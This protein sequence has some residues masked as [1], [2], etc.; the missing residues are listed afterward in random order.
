MQGK[1][2]DPDEIRSL[3]RDVLNVTGPLGVCLLQDVHESVATSAAFGQHETYGVERNGRIALSKE[4]K[5]RGT[6]ILI[7]KAYPIRDRRSE[8]R[9]TAVLR[10]DVVILSVYFPPTKTKAG[11]AEGLNQPEFPPP[12]RM[13]GPFPIRHRARGMG[14]AVEGGLLK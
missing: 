13:H 10:E 2:Y 14:G 9:W 3:Y 5:H 6:I 8:E 4:K 11:K 1:T 7:P 12:K